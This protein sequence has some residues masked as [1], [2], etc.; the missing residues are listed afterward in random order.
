METSRNKKIFQWV[1]CTILL[2]LSPAL[3]ALGLGDANVRSYLGQP[4]DVRIDLISRSEDELASVSAGLATADDFQIIGLDRAAL[5]VPL[6]FAV[7]RE[8]PDAYIQV[9]STLPVNDP[10][11]QLVVQVNFPG[12]RM[13]RQ[14][15]LFLDPPTFAA[16]V[17]MPRI[18]PREESPA[19]PVQQQSPAIPPVVEPSEEL[20]DSREPADTVPAET[21]PVIAEPEIEEQP[22]TPV[23]A[24]SEP[25]IEETLD[26]APEEIIEPEPETEEEPA[27]PVETAPEPEIESASDAPAETLSD[28]TGSVEEVL[29]GEITD[30]QLPDI[31][32][33][34]EAETGTGEI[35][36]E[37]TGEDSGPAV[38][39]AVGAEEEPGI[40]AATETPPELAVDSASEAAP[41]PEPEPAPVVYQ[42]PADSDAVYGPVAAGETMWAIASEFTRGSGYS[43]NQAM[44]A[45]QRQ[46]PEAFIDN[47]INALKRGA[48]LRLPSLDRLGALSNREAML[49][50]MRQEQE[51]RA[52]VEGRAFDQPAPTVAD[53][54]SLATEEPELSAEPA[55]TADDQAVAGRLEL[56]P[57]SEFDDS[58]QAGQGGMD[59]P[60][61][62][63]DVAGSADQASARTEEDLASAQQENEY[64]SARIKELE[65]Q[66]EAA[67]GQ[68]GSISDTG[69]AEMESSLREQRLSGEAE[70]PVAVVKPLEKAAWYS[71]KAWWIAALLALLTGGLVWL[72]LRFRR[73]GNIANGSEVQAIKGEAEELLRVLEPEESVATPEADNVID[74]EHYVEP[75]PRGEGS[76]GEVD[77]AQPDET[78]DDTVDEPATKI[79]PDPPQWHTEPEGEEAVELDSDDPETKLDLA[80]A[81]ISMGDNEAARVML[82]EV[83]AEG[84]DEQVAEARE[85]MTEI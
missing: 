15:T 45:I 11:V 59:S 18:T 60:D 40:P 43:I 3:F 77:D 50:A 63:S 62:A 16:P 12:G 14:Y 70:E 52:R 36:Q 75:G 30:Q 24:A 32:S 8:F 28:S 85:M 53:Q 67:D 21:A 17:P 49:E 2:F 22:A 83:I 61:A 26:A 47:N 54:P 51:Y 72:M 34:T 79:M 65:A 48:I 56:V 68:Q 6:Q 38:E 9:N 73:T 23:E 29:S 55:P 64:L 1:T 76:D 31:E 69:L 74:L 71:G 39:P 7:N 81:Y 42:E 80:R 37:E 27:S 33:D 20:P 35:E 4:L 25:E 57:P 66:L 41:E 84:S 82:E 58:A 44:L 19:Q 13:L 10:V 5:S 78:E 46:N